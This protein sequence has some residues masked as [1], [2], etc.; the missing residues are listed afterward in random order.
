MTKRLASA[1]NFDDFEES[2]NRIFHRKKVEKW[3][4]EGHYTRDA[5]LI[6]LSMYFDMA[7][8]FKTILN[9]LPKTPDSGICITSFVEYFINV[10]KPLHDDLRLKDSLEVL[11]QVIKHLSAYPF[12]PNLMEPLNP[13]GF[14]RAL[15]ILIDDCLSGW[16]SSS[17]GQ[18]GPY[19]PKGFHSSVP[20]REKT[21][22][23]WRRMF[24]RAL[25]RPKSIH[26]GPPNTR[27]RNVPI[28][29]FHYEIHDAPPGDYSQRW[30][31][32]EIQIDFNV[33]EDERQI[34]FLDIAERI[35]PE[36]ILNPDSVIGRARPKRVSY[37][38]IFKQDLSTYRLYLDQ[39]AIPANVL[40][41][42][43]KLLYLF[44]CVNFD[45]VLSEAKFLEKVD[46]LSFSNSQEVSWEEFEDLVVLNI[47]SFSM[48]SIQ[49]ILNILY[50]LRGFIHPLKRYTMYW[51]QICQHNSIE[52]ENKRIL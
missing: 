4:D 49:L 16:G 28:T 50:S 30:S 46:F 2:G 38:P 39:L 13:A 14:L 1:E 29:Y 52:Q 47:V 26:S 45:D 15:C 41:S 44:H 20:S 19:P 36:S 24:F 34:D 8:K 10:L 40:R 48:K 25:A 33:W 31:D 17:G 18:L 3:V 6:R 43:M 37:R 5:V 12:E 35:D 42:F 11:Y 32:S 23:D 27:Y 7:P 9:I 22:T 21:S 51:K